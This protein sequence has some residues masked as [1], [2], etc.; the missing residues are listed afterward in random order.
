MKL[1]VFNDFEITLHNLF[2]L[3]PNIILIFLSL[4]LALGS[5][6]CFWMDS[7]DP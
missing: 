4:A 2:Y 6:P 3:E 7:N 1:L 5:T